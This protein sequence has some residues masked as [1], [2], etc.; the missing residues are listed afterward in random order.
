MFLLGKN[1]RCRCC[2]AA[3]CVTSLYRVVVVVDGGG[4]GGALSPLRGEQAN[5]NCNSNSSSRGGRVRPRACEARA[6][7]RCCR[8]GLARALAQRCKIAAAVAL[9][10]AFAVAAIMQRCRTTESSALW[11]RELQAARQPRKQ[12]RLRGTG[13]GAE[14]AAL[15]KCPMHAQQH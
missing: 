7:S 13:S 1:S 9:A 3:V 12:F 14:S 6:G 2:P 5:A 8:L 11:Q 15:S 10:R 4:G